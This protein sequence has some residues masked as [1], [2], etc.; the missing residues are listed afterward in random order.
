MQLSA[1]E[2]NNLKSFSI[3][4]K[5]DSVVLDS[6][7]VIPFTFE[8]KP[9]IDTNLYKVDFSRSVLYWNTAADSLPD[10]VTVSFRTFPLNFS[11]EYQHKNPDSVSTQVEKITNPFVFTY[12]QKPE[13]DIFSTSSLNK[14]GSVSRG[15]TVGNNQDVVVNSSLNLQLS[16]KLS[17]NIDI[18]AAITD[19]NIPIQPEGNTQQLQ[20]FDQVYI[21]LFNDKTSLI[22]GDF[23]LKRPED[24]YFLNFFKRAQGLSLE[25]NITLGKN[26]EKPKSNLMMTGS[27]AISKGKFA[28]NVIQG[29]EANQGPYRLRGNENELFIIVLAGT[30][31]VYI[32]GKLMTRGQE[33]DYIIDY[34]TAE[35]TF[36]AKQ[37][38]TK[39]RRIVVE[40]QYSDKNY[41]RSLFHVGSEWESKKW[42]VRFNVY[43]EQD[44]KNQPLLQDVGDSERQLLE[45]VGDDLNLA[46]IPAVDTVEFEDDQVLYRKIDTAIVA[47]TGTFIYQDV[48]VYSTNPNEAIYRLRFSDVGQGNGNY[49]LINSS[50]NGRV[51]QWIA[52]DTLNGQPR[53]RY[54][55]V[56]QLIAPKKNQ[57]FTLGADY[58]INKHS[59]LTVE[60]AI[61]NTDLNQFSNI[62]SDDDAG[63]ATKIKYDHVVPLGDLDSTK[64]WNLLLG[65]NY[66][67]VNIN[68]RPIERFRTVEFE[69]DWNITNLNADVYQEQ[70]IAGASV[71][72][73][74]NDM[75]TVLYSFNTFQNGNVFDAYQNAV[76]TQ[77]DKKGFK[78]DFNGSYSQSTG[79]TNLFD[80]ARYRGLI[81]KSFKWIT[82]GIRDELEDNR[83]R[84]GND[85]LFAN[86]YFFNERT[87]FIQSPDTFKNRYGVSYTRRIDKKPLNNQLEKATL[88]ESANVFGDLLKNPNSQLRSSVTY[89]R[90]FILNDSLANQQPDNTL[91]S[92]IEYS[93]RILKGTI[94]SSTFYEV[95]SGLEQKKSF[96]Y[97]EVEPGLG[98]YTY[99]GDFNSNGVKDLNEFG[100]AIYQDQANYIRVFSPTNDYVKTYTNQFSES[101]NIDP[102]SVWKA[103]KGIRKFLSRFSNQT[104]YRIDR[105]TNQEDRISALNPF[106]IPVNDTTLI[107]LNSS[108]RNTFFFNKT[109]PKYGIEHSWQDVRSKSLLTNG[110]ES[111]SN[112]YH[113]I[114]SRWNVTRK[115]TLNAN[116]TNGTKA[117]ASEFFSVNNFFIRYFETEPKITYQP[118]VTFRWSVNFKYTEKRNDID[119][120]GENTFIRNLGTEFKYSI[121]A[122]G[123]V[124]A[125]FNYI[126]I[127]YTGAETSALGFEMLEGLRTGNNFTW[128]LS[129]Q[130]RLSKN[131]QLNLAYNGRKSEENKTIHT[132]NVQVRAFF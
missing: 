94:T 65:A 9:E 1:Q 124:Q 57:L 64:Q 62:D 121:L 92:R 11:A 30:E 132:G 58:L 28:R 86:S 128:V 89:R 50:A 117:R 127:D 80:F 38:I 131:M 93:L 123:S 82:L 76:N 97:V 129:S 17:N 2:L 53:G 106:D 52:P 12:D 118:G 99:I 26:P 120:G 32:D 101:I 78:L 3:P 103:Q 45:S 48:Y 88:G 34:N 111:Y 47:Q 83:F 105:K 10:S 67:Y 60:G 13:E 112:K 125:N 24:S 108:F 74:K 63:Y 109:D 5:A 14:N 72:F 84:D 20:D 98:A 51:F 54:E 27:G 36:T 44:S 43:S 46:V 6:L 8:I 110:F 122:K 95:G 77:L 73:R 107:T 104:V 102:S 126:S 69:R 18:V 91:I 71:G 85:S 61:S 56:I 119:L 81:S 42:N 33:N 114:K 25:H 59:K 23:Q 29:I 37:L 7:S 116:Y 31:S 113:Q 115:F 70:H 75:G 55:P 130:F 40:F 79:D 49:Q 22:A 19:N 96:S 90:L 41:V 66:E 21:K 15:I 87:Y 68:F 39:D 35:V 4:T 16:G 100:E